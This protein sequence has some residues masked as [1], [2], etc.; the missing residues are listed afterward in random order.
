MAN[1][2]SSHASVRSP[3]P[4]IPESDDI[5]TEEALVP[6]STSSSAG[7]AAAHVLTAGEDDEEEVA[8]EEDGVRDWVQRKVRF[9]D[10][11]QL[12]RIKQD[13]WNESTAFQNPVSIGDGTV[14]LKEYD[15]MIPEMVGPEIESNDHL[16]NCSMFNKV[17]DYALLSEQGTLPPPSLSMTLLEEFME[18]PPIDGRDFRWGYKRPPRCQSCTTHQSNKEKVACDHQAPYKHGLVPITPKGWNIVILDNKVHPNPWLSTRKYDSA[19]EAIKKCMV[20][21]YIGVDFTEDY[22]RKI[23][24]AMCR[25]L[26]RWPNLDEIIA[27]DYKY[28][29]QSR[30]H[31]FRDLALYYAVPEHPRQV[32]TIQPTSADGGSASSYGLRVRFLTRSG[33]MTHSDSVPLSV[34]VHD[35]DLS[36]E[37]PALP[38][39][40]EVFF[41]EK[42]KRNVSD[43]DKSDRAARARRAIHIVIF[44][45]N[46][47][48]NQYFDSATVV[49]MRIQA[50]LHC[51]VPARRTTYGIF[52]DQSP[53]T[54]PLS[55]LLYCTFG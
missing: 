5:V 16:S 25:L 52:P 15:R 33:T 7:H 44:I 14:E 6:T 24:N 26:E 27:N 37:P 48:H 43:A 53:S 4:E 29:K 54:F 55:M 19:H 2:G 9:R 20:S 23:A 40:I 18:L 13:M 39:N 50:L 38:P 31:A 10:R 47:L 3:S 45:A 8:S 32:F 35:V 42:T 22:A 21:M 34:S 1:R 46:Q 11:T 28:A 12:K 36:S 17:K 30:R 41:R 49:K 51:L